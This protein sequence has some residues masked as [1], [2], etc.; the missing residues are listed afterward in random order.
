MCCRG[1]AYRDKALV[2]LSRQRDLSV[3]A[4]S[5]AYGCIERTQLTD[6]HSMSVHEICSNK[7]VRRGVLYGVAVQVRWLWS[8]AECVVQVTNAFSGISIISMYSV[9]VLDR[10][11]LSNEASRWLSD[12][13][14]A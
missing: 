9:I 11:G 7:V 5:V 14:R 2:A 12:E 10:T 13:Y 1:S 6:K 8:V 3:E 4:A